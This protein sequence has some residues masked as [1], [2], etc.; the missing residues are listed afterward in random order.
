MACDLFELW[1][2]WVMQCV[3]YEVRE[4]CSNWV[5]APSSANV[6]VISH[7]LVKS[8]I[9]DVWFMKLF[10]LRMENALECANNE[11]KKCILVL[12]VNIFDILQNYYKKSYEKDYLLD[13]C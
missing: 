3:I 6:W 12:F 7:F 10:L 2:I 8:E 13:I 11:W 9:C 5:D 1:V 4:L